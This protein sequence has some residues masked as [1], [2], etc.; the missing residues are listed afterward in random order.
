MVSDTDCRELLDCRRKRDTVVPVTEPAS[1]S[2]SAASGSKAGAVLVVGGLTMLLL[3]TMELGGILDALDG[4]LRDFFSVRMGETFPHQ[5]SLGLRWSVAAAVAFLLPASML[6]VVPGWRRCLLA[7]GC[8]LIMLVWA[9]VL[10]L[11]AHQPQVSVVVSA[12]AIAAVV[13]L[14][15]APRV[16]KAT[17][18]QT[19]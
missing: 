13:V 10:C 2:S 19:T 1:P 15:C 18:E 5:L 12:A 6:A 11:T 16:M 3:L 14:T 9:P 8:T 4:R 17:P 7:F